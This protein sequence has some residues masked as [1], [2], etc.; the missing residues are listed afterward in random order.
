MVFSRVH[1]FVFSAAGSLRV[2]DILSLILGLPLVSCLFV[3]LFFLCGVGR[4]LE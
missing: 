1:R 4:V 3:F 2:G